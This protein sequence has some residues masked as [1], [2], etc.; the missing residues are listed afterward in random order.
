MT[1]F[2]PAR[3]ETVNCAEATLRTLVDLGAEVWFNLPGRGIYPLLNELPKVPSLRYVTAVHEFPLAAMADGYARATGRVAHLG[4][5]MSTGS[6][7]A[8][9]NLFLARRDR[10]PILVTATQTESWAV[11][12]GARAES[13]ELLPMMKAVA[14]WTAQPSSPGRVAEALRRAYTIAVTPPMGPV[15]VAIPVDFWGTE[16]QYQPWSPEPLPRARGDAGLVIDGIVKMLT[17][18]ARPAIVVGAE[19]IAAGATER[20]SV[21]ARAIG[22]PVLAEPDGARIPLPTEH[23]LFAGFVDDTRELLGEA[24][25]VLHVGVN[26]YSPEHRPIFSPS[27]EHIWV[28]ADPGEANKVVLSRLQAIGDLRGIMETIYD[29]LALPPAE[30]PDSVRLSEV[31]S[32]IEQRRQ[33]WKEL[34][35]TDWDASPMS[36]ARAL[37]ELRLALPDDVLVIDQSTTATSH[38][39]QFLPIRRTDGY[40]AASGSSQ[41]WALGAAVGAG[42]GLQGRMVVCITGDGGL[43]FGMQALWSLAQYRPPVLVV[44]LDN[45]GWNSMRNSVDRGAPAAKGM[46]DRNYGWAIDYCA[47]AGSMGIDARTVTEPGEFSEILEAALPLTEPL[48]LDVRVR[49]EAVGLQ[50]GK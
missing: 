32:R 43:M 15:F 28:G 38:L 13:D 33:A 46:V 22:A 18:A 36:V 25:V 40:L 2:A 47:L 39:R 24:D 19:A 3:T 14:K 29:A 7:N 20:V 12:A 35:A 30:T 17:E 5:Y 41:G 26:S 37:S 1:T 49:R 44:L 8:A 48:M 45:G 31:T 4:L 9:S 11:G 23:P 16:V 21:L 50:P 10:I 6:M 42:L 27:A 34:F